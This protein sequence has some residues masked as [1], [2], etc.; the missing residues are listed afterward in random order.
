MWIK[1]LAGSAQL[2]LELLILVSMAVF[3]SNLEELKG[4]RAKSDNPLL[5]ILFCC[6]VLIGPDASVMTSWLWNLLNVGVALVGYHLAAFTIDWKIWGRK[7]MQVCL[8]LL[9]ELC[10]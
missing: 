7:R 2:R 9:C 5:F 6:S 4:T 1:I 3:A 10:R 8:Q